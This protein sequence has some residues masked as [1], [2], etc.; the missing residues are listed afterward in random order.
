[1][2]TVK[3]DDDLKYSKLLSALFCSTTIIVLSI[4]CLLNNL[5][6]DVYSAMMLL[7]IVV[8]GSFCA[9][10]IGFSMGHIFDNHSAAPV[11]KK[12]EL[13]ESNEAYSMPSM[14]GA[15][16]SAEVDDGLGDA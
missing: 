2:V 3:A 10:F 15:D 5:S 16:S 8:P 14:F 12:V 9:W 6:F 4:L 7:R 1:M 11:V 13:S